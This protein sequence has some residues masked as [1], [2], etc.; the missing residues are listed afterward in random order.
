MDC[1]PESDTDHVYPETEDQVAT[2][3]SPAEFILRAPHSLL[4][5]TYPHVVTPV[6][7]LVREA[8]PMQPGQIS[9]LNYLSMGPEQ[10]AA[11][12]LVNVPPAVPS[13]IQPTD[14]TPLQGLR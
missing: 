12:P 3:D 13:A 7:D 14:V 9:S 1:P 2:V 5:G 11:E 8:D 10:E 6:E 4:P